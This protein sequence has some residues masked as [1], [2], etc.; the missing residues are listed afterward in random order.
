[1]TPG[2]LESQETLAGAVVD[3]LENAALKVQSI[4]RGVKSR[5]QTHKE[6]GLVPT[7]SK[8][9][10]SKMLGK[11]LS[12]LDDVVRAQVG[13]HNST[14][15]KKLNKF[16]EEQSKFAEEQKR[17]PWM[18]RQSDSV[19][20]CWDM[21]RRAAAGIRSKFVAKRPQSGGHPL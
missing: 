21:S 3:D 18:L 6:L 9:K 12:A 13:V 16:A 11:G 20:V 14:S 5:R 19:R 2:N 4:F 7:H 15:P 8:G 10:V 17:V 1:M